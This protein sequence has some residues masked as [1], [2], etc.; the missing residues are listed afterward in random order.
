M[1][2]KNDEVVPELADILASWFEEYSIDVDRDAMFEE[3]RLLEEKLADQGEEEGAQVMTTM[4]RK[5]PPLAEIKKLDLP[6]VFRAMDVHQCTRFVARITRYSNILPSDPRVIKLFDNHSKK[7]GRNYVLL[8]EFVDF[9]EE[10]SKHK[11][12][13]VR[14]NLANMDIQTDYTKHLDVAN[15]NLQTDPRLCA[16]DASLPRSKLSNNDE[17]FNQLLELAQQSRGD[18]SD[19]IWQFIM[20]IPTNKTLLK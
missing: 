16:D 8:S 7:V 14:Q 12:E 18:E 15:A 3:A 4:R 9:Y 11:S 1:I 5:D 6:P 13:A 20:S 10:Q 19:G 2:D 17:L